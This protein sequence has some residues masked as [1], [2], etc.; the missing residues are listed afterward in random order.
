MGVGAGKRVELWYCLR[1]YIRE[2]GTAKQ[3]RV[4]MNLQT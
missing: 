1:R 4:A 3:E 2:E